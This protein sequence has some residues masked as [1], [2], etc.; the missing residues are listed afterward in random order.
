M[1]PKHLFILASIACSSLLGSCGY[2]TVSTN[3][4]GSLRITP[5]VIIVPSK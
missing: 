4:D 5:N 2:A 1:K 3:P